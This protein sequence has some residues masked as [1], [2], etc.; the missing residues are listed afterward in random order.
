MNYIGTNA[1]SRAMQHRERCSIESDAASAMMR[2]RIGEGANH[3]VR[4][5]VSIRNVNGSPAMGNTIPGELNS[6]RLVVARFT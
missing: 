4:C 5:L 3:S 1:A 6:Q 2:K